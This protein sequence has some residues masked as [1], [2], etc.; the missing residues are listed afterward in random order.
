MGERSNNQPDHKKEKSDRRV[1]EKGLREKR[2]QRG[3]PTGKR[4]E[5]DVGF[6]CGFLSPLSPCPKR[7]SSLADTKL[8]S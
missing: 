8:P 1:R 2:V 4:R 7:C 3:K 5:G 6:C